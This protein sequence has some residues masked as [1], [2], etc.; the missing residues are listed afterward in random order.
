MVAR[1]IRLAA[2][3]GGFCHGC[4]IGCPWLWLPWSRLWGPVDLGAVGVGWLDLGA[5][6]HG[7]MLL[8][9]GP[10]V[11]D[12]RGLIGMGWDGPSI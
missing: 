10:V 9:W 5:R 6:G 2:Y 12:C 3:H 11:A 8:I 1:P 7:R 4:P